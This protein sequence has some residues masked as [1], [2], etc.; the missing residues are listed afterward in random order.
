MG[1]GSFG[2]VFSSAV[3]DFGSPVWFCLAIFLIFLDRRRLLPPKHA[4]RGGTRRRKDSGHAFLISHGNGDATK[5]LNRC[6][7]LNLQR[8]LRGNG[9]GRVERE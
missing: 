8:M 6:G 4:E 7:R 9:E 5:R 2:G 3:V 1:G